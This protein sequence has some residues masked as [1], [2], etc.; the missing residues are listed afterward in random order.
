MLAESHGMRYHRSMQ[1]SV[2]PICPFC[3]Q[4]FVLEIDPSIPDQEIVSDCEICCRPL[5]I[6]LAMRE[7]EILSLDV[8]P[9]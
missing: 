3:G 5:S 8:R 1:T 2:E 7:A 6:H 4:S 9:A